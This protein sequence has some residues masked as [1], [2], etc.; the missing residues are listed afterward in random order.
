MAASARTY[1]T[2]VDAKRSA[3]KHYFTA[4]LVTAAGSEVVT[5]W[6]RIGVTPTEKSL[7]TFSDH[8]KALDTYNHIIREKTGKGY[9]E[10]TVPGVQGIPSI[11]V[12]R[13]WSGSVLTASQATPVM[14][15]PSTLL[16]RLTAAIDPRFINKPIVP[17]RQK[18]QAEIDADELAAT[19][20]QRKNKAKW[21]F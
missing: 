17:M 12:P 8:R 11:P 21:S 9:K 7:G 6:G 5:A 16:G 15:N 20:R 13:F 4:V 14:S 3:N 19:M 18:S 2:Y 1:L 10:T